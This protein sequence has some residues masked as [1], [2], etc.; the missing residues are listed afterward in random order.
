[1]LLIVG[2]YFLFATVKPRTDNKNTDKSFFF[3]GTVAKMKIE[4]Y[5]KGIEKITEEE[6]RRQIAEQIHTNSVI[7]D[8]KMTNVRKSTY[9]L[10][11]VGVLV[12][13]LFFL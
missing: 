8:T 11:A 10:V 6:T 2:M 3:Y 13:I 5:L 1:M 4:D 9:V 7:A 12:L